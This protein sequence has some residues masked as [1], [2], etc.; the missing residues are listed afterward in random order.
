MLEPFDSI[1]LMLVRI[2]FPN[3]FSQ[4]LLLLSTLSNHSRGPF[5][6]SCMVLSLVTHLD[7]F[8]FWIILSR[9]F[10]AC[11]YIPPRTALSFW[12][13]FPFFG[14]ICFSVLNHKL[15]HLCMYIFSFWEKGFSFMDSS[16]FPSIDRL[17]LCGY[18][19]ENGCIHT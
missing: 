5:A 14:F 7:N 17:P 1:Y 15:K 3:S 6:S 2:Y 19:G 12:S 8:F 10:W 16:M 4:I 18:R 13:F 11:W 9:V